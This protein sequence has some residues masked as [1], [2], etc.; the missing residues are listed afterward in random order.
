MILIRAIIGIDSFFYFLSDTRMEK[1]L[2]PIENARNKLLEWRLEFKN[3]HFYFDGIDHS[4]Y[5]ILLSR[6][7]SIGGN[8]ERFLNSKVTHLITSNPNTENPKSD[9]AHMCALLNLRCW[10]LK[11]LVGVLDRLGAKKIEEP[12]GLVRALK[13]EKAG[14]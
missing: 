5:N 11:R 10:S 2:Q 1:V 3:C 14:I 6:I 7:Y 8:Y 12:S 4:L 13:N 9:I